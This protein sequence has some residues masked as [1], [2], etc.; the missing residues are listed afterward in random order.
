MRSQHSILIYSNIY[1][2]TEWSNSPCLSIYNRSILQAV[3]NYPH[4]IRIFRRSLRFDR[5]WEMCHWSRLW[6]KTS[7]KYAEVDFSTCV[8]FLL[9]W[10]H[11]L[12]YDIYKWKCVFNSFPRSFYSR[13]KSV[14]LFAPMEKP[15]C[16]YVNLQL[17]L[18]HFKSFAEVNHNHTQRP[19]TRIPFTLVIW[20]S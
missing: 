5:N 13:L 2:N 15:K 18:I 14:F 16:R 12:L 20:R 3:L 6:S 7:Y 1:F 11:S 17:I 10:N 8:F 9:E 19:P 4:F